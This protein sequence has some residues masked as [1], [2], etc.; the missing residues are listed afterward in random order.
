MHGISS[1]TFSLVKGSGMM[2]LESVLCRSLCVL[3]LGI[4]ACV[5]SVQPA[6]NAP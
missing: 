4:S 6:A 2:N 3:K 5:P 1:E